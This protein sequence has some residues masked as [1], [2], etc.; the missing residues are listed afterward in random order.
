MV[1]DFQRVIGVEA[2]AQVLDADRPA[3]RR[4]RAPASAAAPTRS[5][6]STPSSTTRG[7]RWSASRPAATASTPAGTPPRITGGRA[8]RAARHA[9]L[10]A[11]G[12]RRPDA[13]R[14]HSIS[15]GLDYPGVGPEHAWLHDIG[16]AEYRPVTDAE[17]MDAFALLC[18][19]EGIIPAIESAHALAGALAARAA[20]SARDAHASLVNLSGRGDKDVDTAAALV[21]PRRGRDGPPAAPSD[22]RL[23]TGGDAVAFGEAA[24]REQGRARAGRLPAGRL[25]RPWP[26]S[27]AAARGDGRRPA[28]TSSRSACPTP[29]R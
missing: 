18:R 9:H 15:A 27:I 2:R 4:G 7:A 5:A 16:R 28:S 6:S 8:G 20:N 19:T 1:R 10:R 11:A 17:A 13:S 12:R 25:P 21:R 24:A 3:A 29:T 26:A 14:S 23:G 22:A